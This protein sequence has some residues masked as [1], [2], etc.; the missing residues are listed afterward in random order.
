MDERMMD[1]RMKSQSSTMMIFCEAQSLDQAADRV[2][3]HP[4]LYSDVFFQVVV[5]V[6]QTAVDEGMDLLL[7]IYYYYW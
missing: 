1:E 3:V 4:A 2:S 7:L 6:M 5:A